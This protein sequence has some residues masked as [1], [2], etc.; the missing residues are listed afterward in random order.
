LTDR[1]L[2]EIEA[3]PDQRT[4]PDQ[5]VDELVRKLTDNQM[6]DGG[7]PSLVNAYGEPTN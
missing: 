3:P 5:S 1:P 6:G 2:E 7:E 4:L